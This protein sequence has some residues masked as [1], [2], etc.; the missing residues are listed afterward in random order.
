M[1]FRI[2]RAGRWRVL[3]RRKQTL[4]WA[5]SAFLWKTD[6]VFVFEVVASGAALFN[7]Y[8]VPYSEISEG[9]PLAFSR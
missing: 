5:E 7:F 8:K 2:W 3:I 9:L 6:H 1:E 4:R